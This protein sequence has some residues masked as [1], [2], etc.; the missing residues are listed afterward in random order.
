MKKT[1][2][3]LA[4]AV[5]M[6]W[7]MAW[8][9][10]GGGMSAGG[11]GGGADRGGGGGNAGG[12]S[13]GNSAGNSNSW[14]GHSTTNDSHFHSNSGGFSKGVR[15]QGRSST[16]FRSNGN[17]FRYNGRNNGTTR[18]NNGFHHFNSSANSQAY[19]RYGSSNRA[20]HS[21]AIPQSLKRMGVTS[22]PK[23]L[24]DR[25]LLPNSF[26][27]SAP[28]LPTKGPSGGHF[29]S[30]LASPRQMSGSAVRNHMSAIMGNKGFMAKVAAGTPALANHYYWHNYN[31][32]PY[33]TYWPGYGGCW[34][35]WNCGAGFF[36]TQYY[37]GNWWWYDP[38]W[39]NWCWWS[40]GN[41]WWENPATTTVYVYENG[42]YTPANNA[43]DGNSGYSQPSDDQ[44][45]SQPSDSQDYSDQR[46]VGD[47]Q[48]AASAL[49]EG[50]NTLVYKSKDGSCKVKLS[51]EG[52]AFLY[53]ES[54]SP[55]F[56]DSNVATVKFS[57]P[58]E[59][60]LRILLILKDGS[61]EIFNADGTPANQTKT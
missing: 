36:W 52:D 30:S 34:Y 3:T 44:A 59:G 32:I 40:A 43:N 5:L 13:G 31:G 29:S 26:R 1:M 14:S 16:N 22:V 49:A 15:S 57:K 37:G 61:F 18:A 12:N 33:A 19:A 20:F 8:G 21:N 39:G 6:P 25:A 46:V 7:G 17:N 53:D 23:P 48:T 10:H 56:L 60:P 38:W 27:H 51:A 35:G 58:T 42:N 2:I 41:W 50:A 47:D 28:R 54:G 45:S 24:S 55:S 4:M 9:F 11:M